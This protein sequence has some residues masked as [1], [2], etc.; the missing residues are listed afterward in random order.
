MHIHFQQMFPHLVQKIDKD[1]IQETVFICKYLREHYPLN[2]FLQAQVPYQFFYVN[3]ALG[4][5][6][7]A[8]DRT[9]N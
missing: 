5:W 9:I 8:S 4:Y 2:I 3:A 1:Y 6:I 7:E